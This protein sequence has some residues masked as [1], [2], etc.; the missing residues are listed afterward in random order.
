[1]CLSVSYLVTKGNDRPWVWW[2]MPKFNRATNRF[3]FKNWQILIGNLYTFY[4]CKCGAGVP[5]SFFKKVRKRVQVCAFRVVPARERKLE[6]RHGKCLF[7]TRENTLD[8]LPRGEPPPP[9]GEGSPRGRA[10]IPAKNQIS[11]KKKIKIFTFAYGQ[12]RGGWPPPPL[13]SAWP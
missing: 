6:N 13:R 2:L 5:I 8:A 11:M 7:C 12:G 10:S 4:R 3:F 1:M 9:R